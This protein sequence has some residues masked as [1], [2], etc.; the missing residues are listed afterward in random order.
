MLPLLVFPGKTDRIFWF[1]PSDQPKICYSLSK[2]FADSN[3]IL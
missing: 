1:H 3:P 2:E